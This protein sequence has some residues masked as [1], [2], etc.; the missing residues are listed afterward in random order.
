[1]SKTFSQQSSETFSELYK[2]GIT[3]NKKTSPACFN[4]LFWK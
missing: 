2:I 1:M 4:R 3:L